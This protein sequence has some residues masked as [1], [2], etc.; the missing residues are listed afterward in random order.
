MKFLFVA[1]LTASSIAN[2]AQWSALGE[3]D[4]GAFYV[5]KAT[6]APVQGLIQ[7]DTLLNWVEPHPLPGNDA[8]TYMSEVALAYLDCKKSELA[9]GSRTLYEDSDGMGHVVFTIALALNDV[10]LRAFSAGST[11]EQLMKAVCAKSNMA[12]R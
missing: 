5:D 10:R 9:F 1:L 7:V 11:G 8:K 2:A 6:I 12:A 3:N 4:Y